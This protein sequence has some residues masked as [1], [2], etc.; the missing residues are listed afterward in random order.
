MN[1]R[2]ARAIKIGT[3]ILAGIV[4]GMALMASA[5]ASDGALRTSADLDSPAQPTTSKSV[6]VEVVPDPVEVATAPAPAAPMSAQDGD[7][8]QVAV[9]AANDAPA[10][11][12]PPPASRTVVGEHLEYVT[13]AD[14]PGMQDGICTYTFSDGTTA[15]KWA[16]ARAIPTR[17]VEITLECSGW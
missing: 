17:N 3:G 1:K 10:A 16:G 4:T 14:N 6:V 7:D 12:T 15:I 9:P 2:A 11:P 5:N 8:G 13:R